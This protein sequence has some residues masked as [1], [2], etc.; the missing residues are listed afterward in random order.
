VDNLKPTE[1]V[2]SFSVIPRWF[3]IPVVVEEKKGKGKE[4][5]RE[6][7]KETTAISSVS[8]LEG[9][10]G[11]HEKLSVYNGVWGCH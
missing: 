2:V 3:D 9:G 8:M 6:S 10:T 7:E 1:I 11:G 5:D 4:K